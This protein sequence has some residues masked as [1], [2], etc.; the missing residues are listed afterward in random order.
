MLV[1]I[2]YRKERTSMKKIKTIAFLLSVASCLCLFGVGYS[3]WYNITPPQQQN[4]T[5]LIE[6]YSVLEISNTEMTTFKFSMLSFKEGD[7]QTTNFKNSDSGAITVTYTVSADTVR[8]TNGK[9]RVDT[10][11]GY[12]ENT[13]RDSYKDLFGGL[14]IG[15]G[16]NTVSVTCEA[17]SSNGETITVI[18]QKI[19][20]NENAVKEIKGA[21]K[22]ENVPQGSFSFT[23]TYTF[24]IPSSGDNSDNFRQTFGQYLQGGE[25]NGTE[26]RD[27]TKF[28][29]SAYV[30]KIS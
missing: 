29:A 12:D 15:E 22:F 28:I 3:T 4:R 27:V 11:L 30:S 1:I 8:T 17:K 24:N 21:Y 25:N 10:A 9:F 23:I 19:E 16:K 2:Y 26:V 14:S 6:S 18:E 20:E 5:G 13:V 7:A